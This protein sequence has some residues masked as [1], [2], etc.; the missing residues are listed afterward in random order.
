MSRYRI[1][2]IEKRHV[3]EVL[4]V[5]ERSNTR[6]CDDPDFGEVV[7]TN[8]W[9]LTEKD[10]MDLIRES[11]NKYADNG[12]YTFVIEQERVAGSFS[13]NKVVGAFSYEKYVDSY[14][15]I[16]VTSEAACIQDTF[17]EIIRYMRNLTDKSETRKKVNFYVR[18]RDEAHFREIIKVFQRLKAKIK[19]RQDFYP[20]NI[21]A[22]QCS[23]VSESTIWDEKDGEY[24][25]V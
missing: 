24:A 23:F 10:L 18:D 15:V 1:A 25:E 2:F 9:A 13:Q 22:W 21:D 7:W 6:R 3:P 12:S 19:L 11:K 5:E 16:W 17:A 8:C 14:E 20:G 4:R